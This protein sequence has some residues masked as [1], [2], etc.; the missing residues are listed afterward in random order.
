MACR[1]YRFHVGGRGHTVMDTRSARS[2]VGLPRRCFRNK[3][4]GWSSAR[5]SL[6]LEALP[7]VEAIEACTGLDLVVE[8]Q[9]YDINTSER[10]GMRTVAN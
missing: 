9:T 8:H 7:L 1:P 2:G 4:R 6:A 5:C 10:R 3:Y